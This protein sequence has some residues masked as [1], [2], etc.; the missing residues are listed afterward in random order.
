[1]SS[2]QNSSIR[3]PGNPRDLASH[4]R[5]TI[6]LVEDD[7]SVREF[8]RIVLDHAGYAVVTAQD[9]EQGLDEYLANPTHFDLLLSDVMMPNRTGPE[10]VEVIRRVRPD[11]R[12]LFMSAY[13]G[14]TAANPFELATGITLLEKP[15]SIGQL[16]HAVAEALPENSMS[17]PGNSE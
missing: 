8:V 6:L 7:E 4:A 9:G 17:E 1:M 2:K 16:L 13:S 12:V 14:G 5:M 15:F 3:E 10:L 11:A